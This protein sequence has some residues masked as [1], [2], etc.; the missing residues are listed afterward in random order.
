M[1]FNSYTFIFAFLPLTLLVF[2]GL[3]QAGLERSSIF[4]LT[5]MSLAF[6]GW[7]K[8]KYLL[9][10]VPLMLANFAIAMRIG[11]YGGR[12]TP[13]AKTLLMAGLALNLG[14]LGYFKYANFFIDN[15]N[16]LSGLD[17]ILSKVVLPLGISFFIF[18]KIAFLVHAYTGKLER[19]NLLDYS[20]F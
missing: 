1:L 6:Y 7:W 11:R 8:A 15:V 18:Q 14:S 17:L 10:L 5:A 20:L 9:L 19:L 12:R 2:H 16:A 4:A 3:R 13:A